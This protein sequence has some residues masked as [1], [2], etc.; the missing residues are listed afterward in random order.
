MNYGFK[1]LVEIVLISF[2]ETLIL[3]LDKRVRS[4]MEINLY[5]YNL[6]KENAFN[7][8]AGRLCIYYSFFNLFFKKRK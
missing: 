7:K 6:Q 5:F 1:T 8:L 4:K 2:N 3:G